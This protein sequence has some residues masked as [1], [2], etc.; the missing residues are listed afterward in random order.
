MVAKSKYFYGCPLWASNHPTPRLSPLPARSKCF[1]GC[2][3]C[4]PATTKQHHCLHCRPEA[5]ASMVV[6]IVGQQPPN[7][8]T[9]SLA[10][11]KQILLW[12]SIVGQKPP[13]TMTASLAGQKQILLWLSIVGQQPPNT[14]TASLA[15]Q[16]PPNTM[17]ASLAGQQPPSVPWLH[18]LRASNH[19]HYACLQAWPAIIHHHYFFSLRHPRVVPQN[20]FP[21][22]SDIAPGPRPYYLY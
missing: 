15:D 18:Q 8:M 14:M 20:T 2:D 3:H 12:L 17:T 13:N 7:T 16:Q 11:Q 19:R 5:N 10:G 6:S 9:A 1:H 22:K 21:Y 4:G